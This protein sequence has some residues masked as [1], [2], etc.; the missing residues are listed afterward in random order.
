METPKNT[1]N[2]KRAPVNPAL[3]AILQSRRAG[4]PLPKFTGEPIVLR[5]TEPT[6][7]DDVHPDDWIDHL[8]VR[9]KRLPSRFKLFRMS[10]G[11]RAAVLI[12]QIVSAD[13]DTEGARFGRFEVPGDAEEHRRIARNARQRKTRALNRALEF[14]LWKNGRWQIGNLWTL[15]DNLEKRHVN[16]G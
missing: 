16:D 2:G 6:P 15:I 7:P 12:I 14:G 9:P 8:P 1:H 10:K 3:M 13:L 11:E 5:W 4:A